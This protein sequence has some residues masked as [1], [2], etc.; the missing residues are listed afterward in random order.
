MADDKKKKD[1]GY[2]EKV[3]DFVNSITPQGIALSAA[4]AGMQHTSEQMKKRKAKEQ[5]K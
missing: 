2:K 3:L 1:K 5:E 4:T